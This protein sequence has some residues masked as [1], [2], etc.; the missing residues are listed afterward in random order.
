MTSKMTGCFIE[1]NGAFIED[2]ES[3]IEDDIKDDGVLYR[4]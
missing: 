3:F 1:D 4:R 2:D